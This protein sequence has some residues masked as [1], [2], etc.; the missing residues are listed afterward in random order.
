M[1]IDGNTRNMVIAS[2]RSL[3]DGG[4]TNLGGGLLAGLAQVFGTFKPWQVNQV[5]LFSDGQPNIGI[6]SSS[7][8]A[9]IAARAAEHGV[10]VTTIGFGMACTTS[11]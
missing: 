10:A 1:I 7:E 9:R 4:G 3:V 2:I 5:V 11:C 6:T 8:L